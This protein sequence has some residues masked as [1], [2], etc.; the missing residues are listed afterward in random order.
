MPFG[1]GLFSG[2]CWCITGLEELSMPPCAQVCDDQF[3]SDLV[4]ILL[5]IF[6]DIVFFGVPGCGT[7]NSFFGRLVGIPVH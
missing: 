1:G 2:Q 5:I 7:F 3:E 4:V 6:M